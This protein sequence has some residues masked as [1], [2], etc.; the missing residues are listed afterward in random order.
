MAI[1]RGAVIADPFVEIRSRATPEI[2][3]GNVVYQIPKQ[4]VSLGCKKKSIG[5]RDAMKPVPC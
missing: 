1:L 4:E 3:N 2:A 5:S